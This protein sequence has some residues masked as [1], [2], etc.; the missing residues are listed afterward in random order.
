MDIWKNEFFLAF[1][2]YILSTIIAILLM[3]PI[4]GLIGLVL[5]CLVVSKIYVKKYKTAFT[6]IQNIKISVLVVLYNIIVLFFSL[7]LL[8]K[9]SIGLIGMGGNFSL[10]YS[11]LMYS[12]SFAL[13][14][15]ICYW[16][17]KYYSDKYHK[18][19]K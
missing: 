19:T 14:Y 4:L 17:L 5:A 3:F 16:S 7:L 10:A 6:K 18:K 11:I 1:I 2:I 8:D 12:F 15:V 13:I 9:S